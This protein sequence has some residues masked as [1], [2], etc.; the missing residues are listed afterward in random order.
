MAIQTIKR[1]LVV[2]GG[3]MGQQI[4]LQCAAHGFSVVLNDVSDEQ[5]SLARTSL[6]KF[7]TQMA[8]ELQLPQSE[9]DEALN[10]IEWI[11]DPAAAA[12]DVDLLIESVPEDVWLKRR[13]FAQFDGLC[14]LHTLFTTN[15]STLLPKE[16]AKHSKRPRQ[17]AALHFHPNVWDS[18]FVDVMPATAADPELADILRK[19]ALA[20]GQNPIMFERESRGYIINRFLFG[21][22]RQAL[23]MSA[24]DIA[25]PEEIDRAFTGVLNTDAAPFRIMDRV[26]LDTMLSINKF[27]CKRLLYLPRLDPTFRRNQKLLE[28]Y[29]ARGHLGVKAGRGFYQ[30]PESKTDGQSSHK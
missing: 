25:S 5:L 29:V 17:F 30:Y 12:E 9:I 24:Q 6:V 16:L 20:I 22:F 11:A 27:W 21:I 13:I 7:A 14:P 10:R 15:T 2:G 23:S 26:G 19:F 4:S 28:S 3:T 18:N 8:A 1:V